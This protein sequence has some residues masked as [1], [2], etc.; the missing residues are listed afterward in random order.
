MLIL[1]VIFSS[2]LSV[3]LRSSLNITFLEACLGNAWLAFGQRLSLLLTPV[4]GVSGKEYWLEGR[5]GT[6]SVLPGCLG[7]LSLT[8]ARKIPKGKLPRP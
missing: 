1:C 5:L 8:T 6:T 2:I 3:P 4:L 7:H